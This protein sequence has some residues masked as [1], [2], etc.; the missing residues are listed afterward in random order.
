MNL[1]VAQIGLHDVLPNLCIWGR[2][3]WATLFAGSKIKIKDPIDPSLFF[4]LIIQNSK[5]FPGVTSHSIDSEGKKKLATCAI[6]IE[7]FSTSS[8]YNKLKRQKKKKRSTTEGE[9]RGSAGGQW[10]VNMDYNPIG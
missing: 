2:L 1:L 4:K 7:I 6:F 10:A 8:S 9:M 3:L 5:I